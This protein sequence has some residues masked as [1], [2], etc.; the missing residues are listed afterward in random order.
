MMN[1]GRIEHAVCPYFP[2]RNVSLR[3]ASLDSP[4]NDEDGSTLGEIV[5]DEQSVNP[6][7]SLQSKSLVGDVNQV[8]AMLEPV[9][10]TLPVCFGLDGRDPLTLRKLVDKLELQESELGNSGTSLA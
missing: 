2:P 5:P 9:G 1:G 8:L 6:L 3:S 10:Q 7:E 4:I